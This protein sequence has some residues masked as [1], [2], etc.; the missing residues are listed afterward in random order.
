MKATDAI[1]PILGEYYHF[2]G[3]P[4]YK[5]LWRETRDCIFV[6]ADEASTEKGVLWFH[7]QL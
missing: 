7:Y 1:K 6:E 4:F 3:T 5:A 2:D